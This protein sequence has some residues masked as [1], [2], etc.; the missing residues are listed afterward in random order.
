ML[1]STGFI[2]SKLGAP[3][4]EPFAFLSVRFAIVL[5]VLFAMTLAMRRTWPATFSDYLH[6]LVSGAL[7]HGVY[8]GG[9]FWAI[10]NGMPAGISAL[11]LGLQPLLTALIAGPVLHE[12]IDAKHWVGL[13]AGGAGLALV[14]GPKL[15][16]A[17]SGISAVTIAACIV[18]VVAMS[19]GA[20]YQKR[21]VSKIDL[22]PGTTLQ[23]AG[24]LLITIPMS[25]FESWEI[26]WSGDLIFALAWLIFVLSIGAILLLMYL[27][28][29]GSAARVAA[30]FY[31]VPVATAVESYFLFDETLSA[32]Q[33]AGMGLVI[34]A[35]ILI[36]RGAITLRRRQA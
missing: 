3:Y 33:I 2:G 11:V 4:I 13:A 23:Y 22:L 5:P 9:I 19:A 27:I 34:A 24:A 21:F 14:L 30:L 16:L 18:S 15:G 20:V 25:T 26:T 35:Q 1:W 12:K 29:Q 6:C 32:V 28:S 10:D 7:M 17:A 36:Q 8:L 31:L